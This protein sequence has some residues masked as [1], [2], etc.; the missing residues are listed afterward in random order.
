MKRKLAISTLILFA[1][2]LPALAILGLGDIVYDPTNFA[3]AVKEFT[4]LEQQY[5]QLVQ[6]YKTIKS[7]Y[8]Q[9]IW[10][11]K[12]VPVNMIQRYRA[13]STPWTP[14]AATTSSSASGR[15]ERAR[16]IWRWPWRWRRCRPGA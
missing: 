10:M 8:D 4:E 15:R 11:A 7:Q 9:M 13:I 12:S 16:R 3:E 14:S 1:W 2:A 6:T 5:S